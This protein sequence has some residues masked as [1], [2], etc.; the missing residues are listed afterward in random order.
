MSI[1]LPPLFSDMKTTSRFRGAITFLLDILSRDLSDS[2]FRDLANLGML[3]YAFRERT[4]FT[5]N[6]DATI[7]IA[8]HRGSAERFERRDRML[9][10]FAIGTCGGNI[11]GDILT[12]F[13]QRRDQGTGGNVSFQNRKEFV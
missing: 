5:S 4:T 13:T 1:A 3:H 8:Y 6:N 12:D 7:I 9:K 2:G 10:L 11:A